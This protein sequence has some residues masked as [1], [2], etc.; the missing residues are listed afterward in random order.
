MLEDIV[1]VALP[2]FERDL[3]H[4]LQRET[5]ADTLEVGGEPKPEQ[6]CKVV[7]RRCFHVRRGGSC[8]AGSADRFEDAVETAAVGSPRLEDTEAQGC[9]HARDVFLCD[10]G[11]GDRAHAHRGK[12]GPVL[13]Y[14]LELEQREK[15]VIFI[16]EL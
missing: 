7:Q 8:V 4:L 6:L 13:S 12:V 16:S 2:L 15:S 9:V 1:D 5:V 10:F 11:N 3:G 14:V